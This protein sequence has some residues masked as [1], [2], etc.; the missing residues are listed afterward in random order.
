MRKLGVA[1]TLESGV[2]ATYV[3]GDENAE[4]F[5]AGCALTSEFIDERP[6]VA[7]RFAAAWEKALA[8][9]NAN[10]QE[11]RA[12]LAK[13]TFTPDDVVNTV[14]MLKYVM[15][16]DLTAKQKAEFQK[17]IDFAA[18]A[19][20]LPEKVNITSTCR[21]SDRI[22]SLDDAP[23]LGRL[24]A[25][26]ASA[27]AR[28]AAHVTIRGLSKRFPDAAIY[29]N[30]DVDLP[31]GQLV[32]IFGPNGCGKSTLINMIAGLLPTDAGR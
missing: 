8:F 7:R 10:P 27:K 31:S 20:T 29:D 16:K 25:V 24:A 12:Y 11:A 26:A 14:P 4:A 9:I 30:F 32:S 15:V 17:F 5:A 23:T 1:I 18:T 22:N 6:D 21:C 3:L 28:T 19:G 2:I 13:N